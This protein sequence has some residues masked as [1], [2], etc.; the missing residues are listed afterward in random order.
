MVENAVT[1]HEKLT[2]LVYALQSIHLFVGYLT[3]SIRPL[4][5][6]YMSSEVYI[7]IYKGSAWVGQGITS[8]CS[9]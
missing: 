2:R 7:R 8:N 4:R 3:L 5:D 9:I 6:W 1:G